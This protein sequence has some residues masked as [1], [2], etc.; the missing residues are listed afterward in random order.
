MRPGQG[1]PLPAHLCGAEY[2]VHLDF[3]SQKYWN[4]L[5]GISARIA[6]AGEFEQVLG[7]AH[8]KCQGRDITG[9]TG[10]RLGNLDALRRFSRETLLTP[11][12]SRISWSA[13]HGGAD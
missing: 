5:F 6:I 8:R 9:G 12:Y 10:G 13:V 2:D 1:V 11:S 4:G 3:V 7:I